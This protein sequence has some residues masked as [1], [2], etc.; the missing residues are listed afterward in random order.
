MPVFA[1]ATPAS[2]RARLGAELKQLYADEK[3]AEIGPLVDACLPK[4][5]AGNFIATQEKSDVVHEEWNFII[6]RFLHFF[7]RQRL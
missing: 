2:E 1:T 5:E 7:W 6:Y 3:H 4:D